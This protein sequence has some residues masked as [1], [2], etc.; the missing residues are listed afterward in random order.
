MQGSFPRGDFPQGN[1]PWGN[2]PR[3]SSP[4]TTIVTRNNIVWKH[5]P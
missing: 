1:S 4:D 5:G 3:G 2:F